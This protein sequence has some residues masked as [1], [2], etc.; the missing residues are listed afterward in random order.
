MCIM[1][2]LRMAS[3]DPPRQD[4]PIFDPSVFIERIDGLSQAEA[5]LLYLKF[6]NAQG[7]ESLQATNVNGV[8]TANGAATF[9]QVGVGSVT[10]LAT[11]PADTDSTT[12]VPT[13]A[14]VQSAII[15]GGGGADNLTDTLIAGNSAGALDIDMNENDI[16]TVNAIASKGFTVRDAVTGVVTTSRLVQSGVSMALKN[17]VV[18]GEIGLTSLR[19]DAVSDTS[20]LTN[21]SE[22]IFSSQDVAGTASNTTLRVNRS[23]VIH[24]TGVDLNMN[25]NA[26]TGLT[27]ATFTDTTNQSSAYTGAGALSGAYTGA[28]ITLDANGKVT[29]I[30]SGS[31]GGGD[32]PTSVSF[33]QSIFT[34]SQQTVSMPTGTKYVDIVRWAGGGVAGVNQDNGAG[35]N[36]G[37]TGGG[38][39]MVT[40]FR[41]PVNDTQDLY[42][43]DPVQGQWAVSIGNGPSYALLA[44]PQKGLNGG[45]ASFVAGGTGGLP[46][47]Q[48]PYCDTNRG[49]WYVYYGTAGQ[50]GQTLITALQPPSV[51]VPIGGGVSGTANLTEGQKGVGQF[52]NQ[53]QTGVNAPST[54]GVA[55]GGYSVTFYPE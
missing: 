43:G 6:P 40:I 18:G 34:S 5:D 47:S 9:A 49:T 28:D 15:A 55:V 36:Q 35:Y 22:T 26:I 19:S 52:F 30:S 25:S 45:G 42:F 4:L 46:S 39:Q 38:G 31:G 10:S 2:I 14:W 23:E 51:P 7:T 32:V 50:D 29:A 37:G 24:G 20:I 3:S 48:N 13:T 21:M 54:Q 53:A 11:Q 41:M 44:R 12:N 33:T 17:Q 8:F 1:Y 16:T 27:D